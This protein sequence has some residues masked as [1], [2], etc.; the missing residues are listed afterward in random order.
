ME[1]E[2]ITHTFSAPVCQGCKEILEPCDRR[3][4]IRVNATVVAVIVGTVGCALLIRPFFAGG[5][6]GP[7]WGW[8]AVSVALGWLLGFVLGLAIRDR[9]EDG[10]AN[11][12]GHLFSFKNRNFQSEFAALNP[13]LVAGH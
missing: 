2:T 4:A 1:T 13:G 5:N 3:N 6:G 9:S 11:F 12:D 7:V 8:V 10:I